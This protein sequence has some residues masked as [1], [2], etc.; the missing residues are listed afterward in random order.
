M[1]NVMMQR[2][3]LVA[4]VML[5][6]PRCAHA[7]GIAG[8]RFF[9][10][11]LTF[12][13]PAV[14]DEAILP[15]FSNFKHPAEGGNVVDNRLAWSFVRLLTPTI[16]LGVDSGWVHR[17]WGATPRSGFD[18]TNLT[19]KGEVYRDN[20]HEALIAASL[21]W[22]I[23]HSGAQ[24]VGANAADSIQ[25]GIF[26]GKGFGDLP[27]SFS[28]LRPFGITG[29]ISAQHSLGATSTNFGLDPMRVCLPR[30]KRAMSIRFI[31]V[32]LFNT[33]RSTLQNGSRAV[34]PKR[35]R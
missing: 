3:M 14:A 21:T 30:S 10:G 28:W 20:L 35:S 11:T 9:P 1:T 12:D 32:F 15:A 24:G 2:L 34:L 27:D 31:G 6:M 29:A 16:G 4:A 8:N 7:H 25:P 5:A 19:V 23:G 26:F 17:N 33:A 22:G 13:D 18:V